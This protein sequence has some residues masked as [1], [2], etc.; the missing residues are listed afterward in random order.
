MLSAQAKQQEIIKRRYSND[1]YNVV[2]DIDRNILLTNLEK[3]MFREEFRDKIVLEI[4]A[5]CSLF[6]KFFLE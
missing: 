4:G 2:H 1:K 5:G 3:T 6:L